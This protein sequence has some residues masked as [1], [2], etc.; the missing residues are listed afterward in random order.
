MTKTWFVI[1]GIG[2]FLGGIVMHYVNKKKRETYD[3]AMGVIVGHVHGM[4]GMACPVVEYKFKGRT[5]TF[6]A[7][8]GR[9]LGCPNIGDEVEVLLNPQDHSKAYLCDWYFSSFPL[10]AAKFGVLLAI[11]GAFMYIFIA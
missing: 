8:I 6:K 4:E 3:R 9:G 1:I 10:W 5:Y 11:I 2:M 7:K